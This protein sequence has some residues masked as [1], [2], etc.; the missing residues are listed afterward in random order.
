MLLESQISFKN[1]NALS[2]GFKIAQYKVLQ[3]VLNSW[4]H[5]TGVLV[6]IMC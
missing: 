1:I 6:F 4:I 3:E 5:S 2:T